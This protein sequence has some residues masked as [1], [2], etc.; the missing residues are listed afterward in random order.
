MS[1]MTEGGV[2]FLSA[3]VELAFGRIDL[4]KCSACGCPRDNGYCCGECGGG[5]CDPLSED[6]HNETI[7][8]Y[9]NN[10]DTLVAQNLALKAALAEISN[11]CIGEIAMGYK[12]DAQCIG[13]L[14]WNATGL[15]NPE[16][17]KALEGVGDE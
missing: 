9:I 8:D 10:H 14:I 12:L 17:N 6:G 16:L 4:C 13:E 15:T 1:D 3:A 2:G 7:I 5:Y 11:M